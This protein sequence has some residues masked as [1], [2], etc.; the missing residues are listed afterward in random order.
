VIYSTTPEPYAKRFYMPLII[1]QPNN[2]I[3]DN[4]FFLTCYLFPFDSYKK[5]ITYELKKGKISSVAL[6]SSNSN[7][8][9]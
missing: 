9:N 1:E 8:G 2:Q 5:M 7:F 3:I 4:R 6:K